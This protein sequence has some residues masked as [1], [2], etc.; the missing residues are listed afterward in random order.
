[1]LTTKN[2][3]VRAVFL[4][5]G[6]ARGIW[7]TEYKRKV[8][9]LRMR[10]FEP[11]PQAAIDELTAEGEALLRFLEPDAKDTAVAVEA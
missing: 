1:M 9:T 4:W 7:E 8:A 3:R 2:L 6:F 10:P 11:L 5:D